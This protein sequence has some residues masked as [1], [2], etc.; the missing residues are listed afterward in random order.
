M[1]WIKRAVGFALLAAAMLV[2]ALGQATSCNNGSLCCTDCQFC[3]EESFKCF[4]DC[5]SPCVRAKD[6]V[7]VGADIGKGIAFSSCDFTKAECGISIFEVGAPMESYLDLK[8]CCFVVT[9]SCRA[10]AESTPCTVTGD[11]YGSCTKEEFE[12][13]YK[14][15]VASVCLSTVC[16]NSVCKEELTDADGC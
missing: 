13:K 14:E 4:A 8:T 6:C 5:I 7:K 2:P 9:G 12:K 15:S 11:N 3:G 1:A 10:E 16:S